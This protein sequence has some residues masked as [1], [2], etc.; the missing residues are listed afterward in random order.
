MK[1]TLSILIIT[2]TLFIGCK[3][4][5]VAP[6]VPTPP[7]DLTRS[8][9]FLSFTSDKDGD[10]DIY[11][12]QLENDGTFSTQNLVY[13]TNPYKLTN[14]STPDLQSNWSPDGRILVYSATDANGTKEIHAFFFK[15]DGTIDSTINANANPKKLFSSNGDLDQNPSFSP[16]GKYLIWDRRYDTDGDNVVSSSDSRNIYIGDVT[17]TGND[18]Q[19]SNIK[20][21]TNT[22]GEDEYNPKWSPKISVRKVA[23]E[24]AT[25]ATASDHDIYVI[26]PLAAKPDTTNKVFFNPGNSGYPAWAPACD[27]IIFESDK[28]NG[29]FYKI[30]K[31]AYPNITNDASTDV[32]QSSTQHYRYPTRAANGDKIAYIRIDAVNNLGNIYLV[33]VNGGVSTKLLPSSAGFDDFNNLYPAW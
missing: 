9:K 4:D 29:G 16:D 15:S 26:D 24:F 33:S 12:A 13:P 32:A 20:P 14:N 22:S 31:S 7:S 5:T 28:G 19:V 11:I 30:V 8:G 2:A 27:N 1:T 21:L 23:Y 17:G 6:V 18:L 10:Q 3:K 25:S